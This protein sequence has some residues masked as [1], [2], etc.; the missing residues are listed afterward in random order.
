MAMGGAFSRPLTARDAVVALAWTGG[1]FLFMPVWLFLRGKKEE[2]TLSIS[3]QGIATEIGSRKGEAP[4]AKVSLV[5]NSGRH[6][7]IA[8]ATGNAF[9]LPERAFND[10]EQKAEFIRAI[11]NWRRT[12]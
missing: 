9:F 4:W 6:L 12:R 3:P 7:L 5:S 10:P 1:A 11:D 2:R 8:S